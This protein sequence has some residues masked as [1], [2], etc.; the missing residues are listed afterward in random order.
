MAMLMEIQLLWEVTSCPAFGRMVV[1]FFNYL[2][3]I[4]IYSMYSIQGES[5]KIVPITNLTKMRTWTKSCT[6]GKIKIILVKKTRK[7][8]HY[9]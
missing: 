9:A 1:L 3:K 7:K 8:K 5:Y 6:K 2:L 4:T